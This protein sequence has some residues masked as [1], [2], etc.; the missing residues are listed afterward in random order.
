MRLE[1]QNRRSGRSTGFP[2]LLR[3]D[4]RAFRH[5]R[6]LRPDDIGI[7]RRLSYP[8]AVAA[9]AARDD[10]FPSDE[11]RVA[12]YALRDEFRVLDEIRLRFEHARDQHLALGEPDAL[13]Y[14]PFVRVARVGRLE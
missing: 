13:E 5:R 7:H 8:G 12:P 2:E 4:A 6:Q 10:I 11:V 1:L 14:R 3:R 9:V